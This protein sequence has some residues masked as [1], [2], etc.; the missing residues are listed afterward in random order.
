MLPRNVPPNPRPRT[1][2]GVTMTYATDANPILRPQEIKGCGSPYLRALLHIS[3]DF[4]S[5]PLTL[6]VTDP[7][8]ADF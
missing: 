4:T 5:S 1:R 8:Q 7:L 2:P 3:S 6:L